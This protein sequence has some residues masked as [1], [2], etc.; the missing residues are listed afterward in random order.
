MRTGVPM[1]IG[2][3]AV[4]SFGLLPHVGLGGAL[5]WTMALPWRIP[6]VLGG[7]GSV[8][9][10]HA[11]SAASGEVTFRYIDVGVLAGVRV[12]RS[13]WVEVIPLIEG[14]VGLITTS[15]TGVPAAYD[16]TRFSSIV[17][18]GVLGRISLG[19][20]LRFDVMPSLRAPLTRDEF[21]ALEGDEL[22]RV[23]RP[24]AA[25]ARL[26]VGIAYEF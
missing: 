11:V 15:A 3:S 13:K 25:E 16:A 12:A 9:T 8:E 23:H 7:E 24:L 18:V 26:A 17:G 6:I 22:V 4:V 19:Q 1:T 5:R 10:S 21:R 20:A 14:R 2:A